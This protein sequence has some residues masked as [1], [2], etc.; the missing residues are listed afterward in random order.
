MMIPEPHPYDP[1][2][3]TYYDETAE[4]LGYLTS[5]RGFLPDPMEVD[6]YLSY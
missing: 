5:D 3:P 1:D 4:E 2:D 6:D